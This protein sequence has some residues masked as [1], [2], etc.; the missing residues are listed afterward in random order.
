ME[1]HFD[2]NIIDMSFRRECLERFYKLS[3]VALKKIPTVCLCD[4][5]TKGNYLAGLSFLTQRSIFKPFKPKE[6]VTTLQQL[7]V[8]K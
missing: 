6:L 3:Q 2:L 8:A 1:K 5:P 4:I 7:M